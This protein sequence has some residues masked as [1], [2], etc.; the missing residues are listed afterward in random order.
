[1]TMA[2]VLMVIMQLILERDTLCERRGKTQTDTPGSSDKWQ[3]ISV[4]R[5]AEV[6][7]SVA[8]W[9]EGSERYKGVMEMERRGEEGERIGERRKEESEW[10]LNSCNSIQMNAVHC[11]CH[12]D[13]A[14]V[15]RL[16]CTTIWNERRSKTPPTKAVVDIFKAN[17]RLQWT[18][19]HRWMRL[20]DRTVTAAAARYSTVIKWTASK[21]FNGWRDW[22]QLSSKSLNCGRIV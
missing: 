13:Y 11:A 9:K 8:A 3:D 5:Q 19:R 21:D 1:M 22:S 7:L 2:M 16:W 18:F 12:V 17:G 4:S 20:S 14:A 10:K 6:L 15:E